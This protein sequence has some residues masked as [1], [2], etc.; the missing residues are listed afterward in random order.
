[1]ADIVEDDRAGQHKTSA[2]VLADYC[3]ALVKAGW[4]R[5]DKD[6]FVKLVNSKYGTMVAIITN[7]P[8]G[9]WIEAQYKEDGVMQLQCIS[10]GSEQELCQQFFDE[11]TGDSL[12]A[13]LDNQEL[14]LTG[15]VTVH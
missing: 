9:S 1:M 5:P 6:D 4:R 10:F 7:E 2:E 3:M 8:E 13:L 12:V 14:E 11:L 15:P